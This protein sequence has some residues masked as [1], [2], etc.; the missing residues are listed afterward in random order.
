[1]PQIGQSIVIGSTGCLPLSPNDKHRG[2]PPILITARSGGGQLWA[3]TL[4][5]HPR[6]P[7]VSEGARRGRAWSCRA[8]ASPHPYGIISRDRNVF[9]SSLIKTRC[10]HFIP[11]FIIFPISG[12]L[13]GVCLAALLDGTDC[14]RVLARRVF[15]A[16]TPVPPRFAAFRRGPRSQLAARSLWPAGLASLNL[17]AAVLAFRTSAQCIGGVACPALPL[18][19]S[20]DKPS[21]LGSGLAAGTAPAPRT[22]RKAVIPHSRKSAG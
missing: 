15:A 22:P 2:C 9:T 13:C 21:R 11:L 14:T 16:A 5:I 4:S 12:L 8:S 19:S 18:P 6:P 17:A 7:C 1:M 20:F 10:P 3:R